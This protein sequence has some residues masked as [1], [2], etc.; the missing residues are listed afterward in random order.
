[1]LKR[2][3]FLKSANVFLIAGMALGIGSFLLFLDLA[4]DVLHDEMGLFD[5]TII[6]LIVGMRS[7]LN[8][9]IMRF[10]TTLGSALILIIIA[11]LAFGYLWIINHKKWDA[12]LLVIALAGASFMNWILKLGFHRSRPA[13]PSLALVAG[14]SF[15]SGHA[16]TSLVF[17]GM[18]AYLIW[19]NFRRGIL[20]YLTVS[21]LILL[22]LA[23]GTSRIYLGVHYPSDVLAGYA[24]G[25]F[26]LIGCILGLRTIKHFTGKKI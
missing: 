16:M 8:T 21:L 13:A 14:Y 10:I 22:I 24:A 17:Y 9:E 2:L 12:Y 1:M 19:L 4:E 6:G 15:P 18:L 7:P 20:V 26:W 5:Q 23:I 25:G 3:D 11:A